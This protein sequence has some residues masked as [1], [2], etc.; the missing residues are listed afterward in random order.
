MPAAFRRW[1]EYE[2]PARYLWIWS[3]DVF[4]GLLQTERYARAILSARSKDP[5]IVAGRLKSRM[6]RQARILYRDDPPH[7]WFI[8]DA[9]ALYRR[10]GS[11]EIMAEQCARAVEVAELPNVTMAVMP[12]VEHCSHESGFI[13]ADN[14]VYAEHAV[15][16]GVYQDQTV[17]EVVAWFGML[18]GES[19]RAAESVAL[20]RKVG[21]VW[22]SGVSPLTAA[23]V[24]ETA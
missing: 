4:H 15:Q 24:A 8:V 23:A 19:Y 22:A 7:V 13:I 1:S 6:E 5:D 12:P 2:D 18:Q 11:A 17:S 21:G 16:G 20:I 10:V 3:P 14:A 9:M